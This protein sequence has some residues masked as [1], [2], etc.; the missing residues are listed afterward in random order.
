MKIAAILCDSNSVGIEIINPTNELVLFPNPSD[1]NFYLQSNEEHAGMV[2]IKVFDSVGKMVTSSENYSQKGGT[3]KIEMKDKTPGAYY[4][5]LST[6]SKI[7]K[8]ICN[9][10]IF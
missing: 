6:A 10:L 3:F 2:S 9:L 1:G 4:L 8:K 5:H 7:I